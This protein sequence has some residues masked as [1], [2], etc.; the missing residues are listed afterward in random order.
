MV[1]GSQVGLWDAEVDVDNMWNPA[2]PMY[3]SPR[4]KEI[5]G[6]HDGEFPNVFGSLAARFHPDEFLRIKEVVERHLF[7]HE[8]FE[9]IEFRGFN[10]DGEERWYNSQ[11]QGIWDANGRPVRMSGSI[12]DIT[13]RKRAEERQRQDQDFL[14]SLLKAHERDRQLLAL[15][16]HD[17]LMPKVTAA[18]YFLEAL[19]AQSLLTKPRDK[20]DLKS[21]LDLVQQAVV[22]GRRLLNGLRPL[23]LDDEGIQL[24][25]E[26]LVA[27]QS[28]PGSFKIDLKQELGATRLD[29]SL[30]VTIYRIVQEALTNARRYS[31][32]P[33][34]EVRL[35]RQDDTLQ[36]SIRDWGVGFDLQNIPSERLGLRGM[37]RRAALHGGEAIIESKPGAGTSILVRLPVGAASTASAD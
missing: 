12:V 21:A 8:P 20:S 17:G 29:P 27:E 15:D 7:Q 5:F 10:K 9:E 32:S 35:S 3:F 13:H 6:Y 30:E 36:L 26:Y 11:A 23:I 31:R 25:L 4:L 33:K 14:R 34:V 2:S 28:E 18:Q 22:E 37:R 24:A 19:A 1:K 16:F